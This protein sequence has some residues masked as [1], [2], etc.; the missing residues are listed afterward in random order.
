MRVAD[1]ACVDR[2]LA[3]VE[4]SRDRVWQ[5]S[6]IEKVSL[7]Q[8]IAA[9]VWQLHARLV[10]VV[11]H[12][13]NG[14]IGTNRGTPAPLRCWCMCYGFRVDLPSL[15]LEKRVLAESVMLEQAAEDDP[16]ALARFGLRVRAMVDPDG[17]P[18][19]DPE[20]ARQTQVFRYGIAGILKRAANCPDMPLNPSTSPWAPT[21]LRHTSGAGWS[22]GTRGV[23]FL[24]VRS[25]RVSA[26]PT[27][28]S[29]GLTTA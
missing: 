20:P 16:N 2:E 11:S 26:T 21:A 5:F 15:E 29:T 9:Q 23:R 6:D 17:P 14:G 8:G 27:T 19:V 4:G 25:L 7:A 12:M 24:G 3:G 1:I 28:F 18:P 22:C 13:D 10:E